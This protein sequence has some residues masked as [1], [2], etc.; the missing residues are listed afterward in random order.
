MTGEGWLLCCGEYQDVLIIDAKSLAVIH[1]FISSQS[2]DWINCMCIVHSMRIQGNTWVLYN[3]K[4]VSIKIP[5]LNDFLNKW[6]RIQNT[7]LSLPV[8]GDSSLSQTK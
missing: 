2:P 3:A 1:T 4:R 5:P 6:A 7:S 8:R